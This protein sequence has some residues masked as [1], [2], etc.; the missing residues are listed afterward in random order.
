MKFLVI[1][2]GSVGRRH[3]KNLK[4]LGE[5]VF[6]SDI[7]EENRKWVE[8]NLQIKTFE[9][10]EDALREKPNAV[11]VCT[12]P[13]THISLALLA[14]KKKAHV[15]IEKPLSH[16]LKGVDKLINIANKKGLKLAVGYNLR[17][18]KSLLKVKELFSSGIIGKVLSAR[19]LF[20]QYLPSWR[21]WQDYR[22]SYTASK[23]MGGGIILDGSHELDYARWLFGEA[24]ELS[25]TAE[26]VSSLEVETEDVAEIN[27]KFKSGTLVNVHLDFI[28]QDYARNCEIVGEK[29]T[30]RWDYT[31]GTVELYLAEIK[32]TEKFELAQDPNEMYLDE[33]KHFIF[34]IKNSKEPLVTADEG[35]HS[36][37]LALK[38]KES[39][40]KKKTVK[41]N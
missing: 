14:L 15:F 8:E 38:A 33:I 40:E 25:C 34:C 5:E 7:S 37:V 22:K 9:S 13:N 26:K 41:V 27:I 23:S 30:I 16:E 21:P 10:A 35:K 24:V 20:G 1:G 36:L 39:A 11:L 18:N 6:A 3:I 29:G 19:I 17:F 2:C 28:R 31:K 32:Q 12:P 4:S